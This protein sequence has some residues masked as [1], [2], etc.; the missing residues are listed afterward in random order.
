V[1]K[2]GCFWSDEQK[3]WALRGNEQQLKT[4]AGLSKVILERSDWILWDFS[5]FEYGQLAEGT[6]SGRQ[7]LINSLVKSKLDIKFYRV[8]VLGAAVFFRIWRTM[9]K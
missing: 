6:V 7:P 5:R 1:Y 2:S 9:T 8:P 4:S 3:T